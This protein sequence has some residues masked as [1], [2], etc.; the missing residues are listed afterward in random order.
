M[1]KTSWATPR[2][3]KGPTP[4]GFNISAFCA[5]LSSFFE[6]LGRAMGLTALEFVVFRADPHWDPTGKRT[7][8][9]PNEELADVIKRTVADAEE[10]I[11]KRQFENKATRRPSIAAFLFLFTRDHLNLC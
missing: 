9:A 2:P 6:D 8:E 11:H 3:A 10:A 5:F 4:F 7:G 1:T